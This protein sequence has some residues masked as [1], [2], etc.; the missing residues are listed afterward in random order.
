MFAPRTTPL[1]YGEVPWNWSDTC[2]SK[3]QC[4]WWVFYRCLSIGYS[5]CC[6]YDGSGSNGIGSYTNAK[7][8][9]QHY[10]D[11]WEVKGLD[12]T[13]VAG[14]VVVYDGEYGHVRFMETNTMYSEYSSG[15][16]NSFKNGTF[17]KSSNILGYLHYPYESLL[18]VERNE[19]VDQIQTTDEG[20]RI[21]TKPNLDA[22]CVGQVQIGYYNV[23]SIRD[24]NNTDKAKEKGLDCWYQLAK[25]RWCANLT[26]NYLPAE[27]DI[28]GELDRLFKSMKRSIQEKQ[29]IIDDR[30]KRLDKIKEI[31]DYE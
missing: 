9:L 15:N 12:Y 23:L 26:T 25:D 4:T 21:R 27:D 13:P 8:W 2:D 20:L 17:A 30:N 10:R 7:E 1:T 11:P 22:E 6:Y 19:Y 24:A 16:P 18:P 29:D 5:A 31:A 14:D 3:F 28:I